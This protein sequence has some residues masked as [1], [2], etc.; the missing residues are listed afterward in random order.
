ML[1][2]RGAYFGIAMMA[3]FHI[4]MKYTQ[5]LFIQALMGVKN[6]YDAKVVAIHILGKAADGDLKRP[7]KAASM[8]GR[9]STLFLHGHPINRLYSRCWTTD[10]RCI[11]CRGRE[12][13][14]SQ[15]GGVDVLC[16]SCFDGWMSYLIF[17]ST[18]GV[19]SVS[20]HI[21]MN[22]LIPRQ[23]SRKSSARKCQC[24]H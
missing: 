9:T 2:L 1:Q 7:F 13:D 10:R 18:A 15:E 20:S 11:Y 23:W 21:Y 17:R 19:A 4:Y 22:N 14:R 12:K 8:F 16:Y 3:F 24:R 5:P 6:L